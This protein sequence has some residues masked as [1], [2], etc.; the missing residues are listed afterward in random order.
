MGISPSAARLNWFRHHIKAWAKYNTRDFPW[1]RT[2]EPYK[3][4]IA[5]FLLQK[6]DADR[7]VPI[8]DRFLVQ[9]PNLDR[10]ARADVAE[11]ERLLA[12]LGLRFRAERLH[13]SA[14]LLIQDY[15]SRIPKR[16]TEL[17]AL[18]GVGPYTAKAICACAHGQRTPVLDVNVARILGRFFGLP[19][20]RL[21][22]RDPDYKA[23][24][25]L[26]APQRRVDRWNLALLDF[27]ALVCKAKR[28]KCGD[29]SLRRRC[30]FVRTAA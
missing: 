28:P 29:C 12:P 17:L 26:V 20:L 3:I 15:R 25:E 30:E 5:E 23:L 9:Y 7:V 6:T 8:Y 16:E 21:P 10:L 2:R 24:A 19:L 22:Q 18:P 1:R 13:Q 11:L 4:F 14:H 27:G